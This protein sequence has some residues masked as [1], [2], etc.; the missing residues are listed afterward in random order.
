MALDL[1]EAEHEAKAMKAQYNALKK[2]Y[3]A[4]SQTTHKEECLSPFLPLQV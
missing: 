2:Q 1:S 3:V 4:C